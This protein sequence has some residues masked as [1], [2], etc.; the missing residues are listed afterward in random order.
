VGDLA[1]ATILATDERFPY[2]PDR[3]GRW[4]ALRQAVSTSRTWGDC[5]G[6]VLVAT[7]RAEVMV[8]D[9]L[10]SWDAGPLVPIIEEAGGVLTDWQGRRQDFPGDAIATN[11]ALA[12]VVRQTLGVG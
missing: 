7:G 2:H 5:Y 11:A 12:A 10:S 9:R 8:D 4:D 6:Y 3:A 1:Q